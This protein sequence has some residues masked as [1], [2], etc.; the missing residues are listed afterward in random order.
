MSEEESIKEAWMIMLPGWFT[1]TALLLKG[2]SML[3]LKPLALLAILMFCPLP[4][5]AETLTFAP[6]P[7]ES[8]YTVAS[9]WLPFVEYLEQSL[10]VKL[11]VSYSATNDEIVNKFKD[12]ELDLAYL[13]PL[14]YVKLKKIFPAAEPVVIFKEE[15]GH[16]AYTCALVTLAGT[17]LDFTR[18]KGMRVALTQPL[19]TCGYF[20]TEGILSQYGSSLEDNLYHFLGQH[21]KV[22]LAVARGDFDVGGLKTSIAQQYIYM[23]VIVRAE[24]PH[25]PGLAIV[26]NSN[27]VSSQR[28]AQIQQALLAADEKTRQHWGKNIRY[29]VVPAKDGDYDGMRQFSIPPEFPSQGNIDKK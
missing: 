15:D 19:S 28:I 9:Q 11:K 24:S 6:L 10:G 3:K 4:V 27:R 22:A 17:N 29:G 26:A 14:P 5:A 18:M 12:G 1:L 2:D 21:D 23:R 13:G 20:A 8:T 16:A 25:M 7:M